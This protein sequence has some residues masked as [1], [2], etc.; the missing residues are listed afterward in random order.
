MKTTLDSRDVR[1]RLRRSF[2]SMDVL[3]YKSNS[4]GSPKSGILVDFV[5]V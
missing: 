2:L 5:N 3:I 1:R 4:S